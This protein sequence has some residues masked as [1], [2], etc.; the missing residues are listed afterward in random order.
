MTSPALVRHF[1]DLVEK[2]QSG[3]TGQIREAIRA[4]LEKILVVE[5]GSLAL[6]AKADGLR[7]RRQPL[8]IQGAGGADRQW[9]EPVIPLPAG[10]GG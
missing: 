4:S 6:T 2:L 3:A 10:I 7:G 1:E 5:D 9:G 8:D